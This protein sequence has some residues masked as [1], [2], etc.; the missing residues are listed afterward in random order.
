ML[1]LQPSQPSHTPRGS[2]SPRWGTGSDPGQ[3]LGSEADK[4][5]QVKGIR[6]A[7]LIQ[8][9]GG[10][11]EGQVHREEVAGVHQELAGSPSILVLQ[12]LLWGQSA[13]IQGCPSEGAHAGQ[14]PHSTGPQVPLTSTLLM[15][16]GL[17]RS[18]SPTA[19]V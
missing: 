17:M 19:G 12:L 11:S 13:H 18:S 14:P 3:D 16:L 15:K 6:D 5:G 9:Q 7:E 4:E 8:V 10:G 2:D 1:H